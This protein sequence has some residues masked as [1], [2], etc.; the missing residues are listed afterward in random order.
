[1]TAKHD[2]P[3]TSFADLGAMFGLD[4]SG[5]TTPGST[6]SVAVY[7][8]KASYNAVG[9]D[10]ADDTSAI[11]SAITAASAAGGGVVYLPPGTYKTTSS[12]DLGLNVSL[13]GA[14]RGASV[15]HYTGSAHAIN[16]GVPGQA[17][18]P[19]PCNNYIS[20]LTVK[21]AG[22]TTSGSIGIRV[23]KCL[24]PTLM[25]TSCE[26]IETGYKFDGGDLWI[27]S[28][29][30]LHI[31]TQNVTNGCLIT[32]NSGKQVN[33]MTFIGGYLYGDGSNVANAYGLKLEQP[34][35]SDTCK[36]FGLAVEGYQGT[37]AKGIWVQTG[38]AGGHSFYGTRT[39]SCT[40][41]F[42]LDTTA[43]N[44]LVIANSQAVT[45]NGFA[46]TVIERTNQRVSTRFIAF[47]TPYTPDAAES[48]VK[49]MA[50]LT[51]N[52]TINNPTNAR[53]GQRLEFWFQ[54]DGTGTR[55]VT[56][57]SKFKVNW[58]PSTSANLRNTITFRYD[59]TDDIWLQIAS[60][61]GL[62]A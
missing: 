24:F 19:L 10:V 28:G 4:L 20:D 39:E 53:H 60:A 5:L 9:N 33:D 27:A 59:Q 58:A 23:T 7:N 40:T 55:T 12:L 44:H 17:G 47:A 8:V 32:A 6:A 34:A 18:A 16:M 22:A 41:A 21:G 62:P 3:V 15:I 30:C 29:L 42:L 31:R 37:G 36:F 13:T 1:M 11:Q 26:Q 46:N 14:A 50:T 61:T 52:I 2:Q 45:D 56:W 51:G 25:R 35:V 57:G 43:T 48:E 38:A 49:W 54:Q